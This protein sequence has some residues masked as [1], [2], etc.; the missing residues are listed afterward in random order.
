[1]C[2]RVYTKKAE[3]FRLR[4][5]DGA[6]GGTRTPTDLSTCTSSMRVCH[7]TT[8]AVN[9][10]NNSK[11]SKE[12]ASTFFTFCLS[13]LSTPFRRALRPLPKR[14]PLPASPSRA[15]TIL[16]KEKRGSP[17]PV[18]PTTPSPGKTARSSPAPTPALIPNAQAPA[19]PEP[20]TPNSARAMRQSPRGGRR[21]APRGQWHP[22]PR[23][24]YRQ[25]SRLPPPPAQSPRCA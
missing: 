3:V 22:G 15:L 11:L 9:G 12:N 5:Q 6:R 21:S 4:L 24:G 19:R 23:Q 16:G 10:R 7:F 14:F 25:P 13:P 2:H 17:R 18:K 1:M 8:R 20:A